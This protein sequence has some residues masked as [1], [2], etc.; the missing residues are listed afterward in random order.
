MIKRLFGERKTISTLVRGV[1]GDLDTPRAD[2]HGMVPDG[3]DESCLFAGSPIVPDSGPPQAT[4][5]REGPSPFVKCD[6][7][8]ERGFPEF[9]AKFTSVVQELGGVFL[10]PSVKV[11]FKGCPFAIIEDY[12]MFLLTSR[13]INNPHFVENTIKHASWFFPL[14]KTFGL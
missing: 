9:P 8:E 14:L 6:K 5:A 1:D 7:R 3:P 2:C 12:N 4:S 10:D 13:G 11:P